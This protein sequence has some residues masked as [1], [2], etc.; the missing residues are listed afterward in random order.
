MMERFNAVKA[1]NLLVLALNNENAQVRWFVVVPDEATDEDL[2]TISQDDGL[3][4]EVTEDFIRI[5][6]AYGW[7]GFCFGDGLFPAEFNETPV[8]HY[9]KEEKTREESPVR[10]S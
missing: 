6:S 9:S 8:H 10:E 2:L 7:E 4:N 3:M 1:M 5:M